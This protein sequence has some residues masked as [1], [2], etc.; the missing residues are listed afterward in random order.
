[1]GDTVGVLVVVENI[2]NV[3]RR[4]RVRTFLFIFRNM[5]STMYIFSGT[6]NS[7]VW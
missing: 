1:M 4:F 6:V 7:Y 2:T 3:S 5:I